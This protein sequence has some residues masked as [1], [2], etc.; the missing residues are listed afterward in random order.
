MNVELRHLRALAAIGDEGTI[1]GAAAALHIS[2]PAL[3]RTL[4]QLE[5]RLG[6]RLVE[7]TTRRLSL[8]DAGRLL[9]ER[10]H[11]ILKQLDDALS[12]A[13]AG[14]R[15]LRIGF[16]WAALGD[17]TVPLLRAWRDQHP[18]IPVRVHRPGDPEA[19][20]RRGEIDAVFLRTAPTADAE[21]MTE[22]LYRERRLAAVSDSDPLV[23]RSVVRLADLADRLVVLCATAASTADLWPRG[24]RPTTI[25]VANVDEWLTTIATGEAVGA[26][27]EATEHSHPHPGVRYLPLADSAPVTVRLVWPRTPTHPATR[28]FL[29]H[30]RRM[31]GAAEPGL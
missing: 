26:T 28:T 20:L 3:S 1:T 27:A 4:E 2:Q 18:D 7:R 16:A 11:L 22:E 23:G 24:Q 15:P 31:I 12:E 21:L 25:E 13:Q 19:A 6:T 14:P 17:R 5:N 10:A 8:T 30:V 29:E 9:H